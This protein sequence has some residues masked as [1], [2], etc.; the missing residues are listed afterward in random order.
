MPAETV[1]ANGRPAGY[2]TPE[3]QPEL[4]TGTVTFLF[5]DIE[6]ST[7]L[8]KRLGGRYDEMLA[9]HQRLLRSAFRAHGGRE[10]DTQGDSFFVAFHRAKDAVAA[11]V[12]AQRDLA[13]KDWPDG[14]DVKVRMGLHTGEP[15][16]GGERY[17]GIGV[18]KAARIGAAGHGGQVLLSRTTRELVEDELP[19]GV[20]IEDLGD[21]RL[22]DID[23]AE[24]LAQIL[25]EGLPSRFAPLKTLDTDL[26]R[27]R[28]TMLVRAAVAGVVVAAAVAIPFFALSH[29]EGGGPIAE[30]DSIAVI[31]PHSNKLVDTVR[32][33]VRPSSMATGFGSIW[34]THFSDNEV[35][36]IDV[37]TRS[38][39]QTLRV[40]GGPSGIAVG[41]GAVWVANNLDGTVSRIDPNANTVVQTVHV[42]S[43]PSGVTFGLGAAWVA[44]T[45]DHT[46]SRIDPDGT[47]GSR[48]IPAG[49]DATGIAVGEGAVW[50]ANP[51]EGTVSR[52][53]PR[54]NTL[55]ATIHVG[56]GPDAIAVGAGAVWVANSRDGTVSRVDP[57]TATV[58][59][60]TRV[61]EGPV[62]LGVAGNAVWVVN[63]FDG[64]LVRLDVS[65]G[66]VVTTRRVGDSARAVAAG[67]DRVWV[68][69]GPATKA[70]RGG[71][72]FTELPVTLGSLFLDSALSYDVVAFPIL[73]STSD[74]LVGF[75]RSVGSAQ[76][77]PDLA[78]TL[79]APTEA[80]RRYTF[81]LRKG[82]RY[83]SGTPVRASDFRRAIARVFALRSEGAQLYTRIL[84]GGACTRRPQHCDLSKGILADD[85]ARTVTFRLVARD[86]DFLYKLALNFAYPVPP[87]APDPLPQTKGQAN[88]SPIPGT[89][90]YMV[91]GLGSRELRLVR[92]PYFREWSKAAQ[93]DGY[94]DEIVFALRGDLDDRSA[95][96]AV[97]RGKLD[98]I[99]WAN[100]ST[101]PDLLLRYRSRLRV[102]PWQATVYMALNT[103]LPPFDDVRVRRALNYAIDRDAL[104]KLL[105]GPVVA[106]PTCQVLPA[107]FPG[108]R[109]YC[110]YRGPNLTK[111][112]SLVEASGTKGMKVIV[113]TAPLAST[114][115]TGHY[116]VSLLRRLGY[117]AT[118]EERPFG[119]YFHTIQDSRNK[120]QIAFEYWKADY[121]APS[122]FI[123]LLLGC[124]AFQP[125][126]SENL[127]TAEFCNRRIDAQIQ[128]ALALQATDQTAAN[129]LWAEI[130]REITDRA[131]WVP[132][133]NPN[134]VTL[135]SKRAGNYQYN[136]Q[137]GMLI[138][139]LWVR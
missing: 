42:G 87:G 16:V 12:D 110:P 4:P 17:V 60:T 99:S 103:R 125:A 116:F 10:V 130:D 15:R 46:V 109:R 21:H 1:T 75:K 106:S 98:W 8:L 57:Q 2:R 83:S 37:R 107:G 85:A 118:I 32:V 68:A 120:V 29:E 55:V 89:G 72:A 73:S 28:T 51:L 74:G 47:G 11:A 52:I 80:G 113:W 22:K 104:I 95:I 26:R 92:N 45:G 94:P 115:E 137:L 48:V 62:G 119:V 70:H 121:P 112:R 64:R 30:P 133:N 122:N 14:V 111:A 101:L 25:I 3:R 127:N 35:S 93:P 7:L 79:P 54:T 27:R 13:A 56:N 59:V 38:L 134:F 100:P 18:H 34:T 84:G 96:R 20:R 76:L 91:A 58:T 131:P 31:D 78:T 67:G 108:Y 126:S 77:V 81:T 6:G 97:E 39:R 24:R 117:R 135:L 102:N 138:D 63:E 50:T 69:V 44:N 9:E 128:H 124:R 86:P 19:P 129:T 23:G 65:T 5:T 114:R 40:R 53:D 132:I 123:D 66:A 33:G 49:G 41:G 88:Q 61:G 36:R 139:Q 105:G 136:A 71:T 43:G 90:P 82:I